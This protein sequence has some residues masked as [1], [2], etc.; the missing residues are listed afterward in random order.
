MGTYTVTDFAPAFTVNGSASGPIT[1]VTNQNLNVVNSSQ[2][3]AAD[4]GDLPVQPLPDR[5]VR[6]QLRCSWAAMG[7][8]PSRSGSPPTSATIPIP[9]T[10]GN[11]A[12]KIKVNYTGAGRRSGR[13]RPASTYFTVNVVDV[14]PLVVNVS[15]SPT[16]RR[17]RPAR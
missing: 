7:D 10:A 12:L 1:A 17:R 8:P 3:G 15:V 6:G 2:R 9:A 4:L 11:Y 16:S 5:S 14:F 13:I